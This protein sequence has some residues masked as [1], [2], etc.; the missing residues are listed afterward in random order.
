M[1]KDNDKVSVLVKFT[2]GEFDRMWNKAA[3]LFARENPRKAWTLAEKKQAV[4][5]I[6]IRN[7]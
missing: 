1:A 3:A 6:I 4:A 2:P 5:Y 7:A